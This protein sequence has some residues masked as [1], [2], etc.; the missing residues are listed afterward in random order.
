MPSTQ[1][2]AT[3]HEASDRTAL[4]S[5]P[6]PE[7]PARVTRESVRADPVLDKRHEPWFEEGLTIVSPLVRGGA[8]DRVAGGND[9]AGQTLDRFAAS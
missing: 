8:D 7:T 5:R 1:S 6:T 3:R 2:T 9:T 4:G